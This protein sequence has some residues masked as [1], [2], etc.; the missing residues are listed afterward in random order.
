MERSQHVHI[1]FL[2]D[3][4]GETLNEREYTERARNLLG[5]AYFLLYNYTLAMENHHRPPSHQRSHWAEHQPSVRTQ[6]TCS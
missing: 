4:Q 3:P 1:P 2:W 6:C 5:K